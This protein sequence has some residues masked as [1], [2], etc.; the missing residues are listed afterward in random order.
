MI[1]LF[2]IDRE[3]AL[4]CV[5]LEVQQDAAVTATSSEDK[6]LNFKMVIVRIFCE[7]Q[8]LFKEE[9]SMKSLFIKTFENRALRCLQL[10]VAKQFGC[11]SLLPN[12]LQHASKAAESKI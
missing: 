6:L 3:L 7:F 8:S 10:L 11:C 4:V 5:N 9:S 12:A 2:P 1:L